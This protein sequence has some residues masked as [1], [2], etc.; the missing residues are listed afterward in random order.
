MSVLQAKSFTQKYDGLTNMLITDCFVC[1]SFNPEIE[2]KPHPEFVH[3]TGLWDTGAT[4]TVIT[5]RVVEQIGLIPT[6]VIN[7]YHANGECLVNTY[8][9]NI[10]L[11]NGVALHTLK[12]TEGKLNGFDVLIGMD[13]IMRGDFSISN[14]DSKTTF[15]FQIPSTHDFDFVDEFND[16]VKRMHT[17]VVKDEKIQRN[18]PCFCGSGKK[19]KNC[20]GR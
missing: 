18:D 13:V 6:G 1:E 3:Y 10:R 4:G 12:V 20:H 14:K 2:K 9:I 19:Y 7:T 16:E 8:L 15:T 17:P 5:K 11:P